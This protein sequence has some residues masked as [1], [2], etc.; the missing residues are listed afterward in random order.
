[1]TLNILIVFN[2]FD[3]C[4]LIILTDVWAAMNNV[5]WDWVRI[6]MNKVNWHSAVHCK[7][8]LIDLDWEVWNDSIEQKSLYIQHYTYKAWFWTLLWSSS[9]NTDILFKR[10]IVVTEHFTNS[11]RFDL[12]LKTDMKFSA[13]QQSSIISKAALSMK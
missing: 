3:W 6:M 9:R 4:F 8:D 2:W 13:S 5:D 12:E 7:N 11:S 1:M 10:R